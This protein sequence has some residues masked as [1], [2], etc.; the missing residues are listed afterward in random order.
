MLVQLDIPIKNA[1]GEEVADVT[2]LAD[3]RNGGHY[4]GGDSLR[5]M[6]QAKAAVMGFMLRMD[7]NRAK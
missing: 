2:V 3:N 1:V 4:L 7:T 5:V 6:D